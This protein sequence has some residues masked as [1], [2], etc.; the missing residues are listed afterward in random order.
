MDVSDEFLKDIFHGGLSAIIE[1]DMMKINESTYRIGDIL[2]SID[3]DAYN[4]FYLDW[5]SRTIQEVLQSLNED[6]RKRLNVLKDIFKK[7]ITPFIG[8]GLSKSSG[9]KLW[10]ELL[11]KFK[12]KSGVNKQEFDK[13]LSA[14]NYEEAMQLIYDDMGERQ[15]NEFLRNTYSPSNVEYIKGVI[16]MLPRYF[17]SNNVVTTN[18]D[19]LIKKVFEKY[20]SFDE[21]YSCSHSK[22]I[23][24]DFSSEKKLLIK[25]HG[26][27]DDIDNRVLTKSEYD[28]HY[29][30]EQDVHNVI[31]ELSRTPLLFMGCSLGKDRTIKTL[32]QI[33]NQNINHYAFLSS[34]GM[35]DEDIKRKRKEL[36]GSN[37]YP[38]FYKGNHDICIWSLLEYISENNE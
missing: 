3:E 6:D 30:S 31:K 33:D 14:G 34:E 38:I 28:R 8:A 17:P 25:L 21:E 36:A 9:F 22:A 29:S 27:A 37:I 26:K 18:F 24:R 16:T 4:E 35:S 7:G 12:E 15:F 1:N 10:S 11:D 2:L 13:F 23:M 20:C 19:P 5:K 32:Q